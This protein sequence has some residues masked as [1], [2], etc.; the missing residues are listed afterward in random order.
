[1][2][3]LHILKAPQR[4]HRRLI[5][6]AGLPVFAMIVL[7]I[8]GLFALAWWHYVNILPYGHDSHH[9]YAHTLRIAELL[10]NHPKQLVHVLKQQAARYM[11]L[12]Y[13]TGAALIFATQCSWFSSSLM[14]L[15]FWATTLLLLAYFGRKLAGNSVAAAGPLA[16]ALANPVF[17]ETGMSYNLEAPLLAGVLTIFTA[18]YY[19][20]RLSNPLVFCVAACAVVLAAQT[21][22]VFLLPIVP[23]GVV[24]CFTKDRALRWR[25]IALLGA[26][27]FS[28]ALW[29]IPH[30]SMVPEE[31]YFDFDNPSAE[32]FPGRLFYFPV[33]LFGF[34]GA[35][36]LACLA[37]LL[38]TRAK[39]KDLGIEDLAFASFFL[40]PFLFY[41]S[42]ETQRSWYILAAW[43]SLPLWFV[44]SAVRIWERKWVRSIA[45]AVTILYAALG[46]FNATVVAVSAATPPR[47][48]LL[49]GFRRPAPTGS[50]TIEQAREA[51]TKGQCGA[52]HGDDRAALVLYQFF[53]NAKMLDDNVRFNLARRLAW[54]NDKE[55]A[56][57]LWDRLMKK[58]AQFDQKIEALNEIARLEAA[59]KSK[60][61][62]FEKYFEPLFEQ[63]AGDRKRLYSLLSAKVHAAQ[64]KKDWTGAL[65]A[66]RQLREVAFPEQ[67]LGIDLD[68]ALIH[69]KHGS[70]QKAEQMLL[71]IL[72]NN[73]GAIYAEAALHMAGISSMRDDFAS[74]RGFIQKAAKAHCDQN[75]LAQT[76]METALKMES[77]GKTNAAAAL[78]EKALES[79]GG[80]AAS[81]VFIELAKL[82]GRQGDFA[83]ARIAYLE[84]QKNTEDSSRTEWLA[85]SIREIDDAKH[86]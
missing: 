66:V 83:A 36:V 54:L 6:G 27:L 82:A 25:R 59:G 19:A 46:I 79:L 1:M 56:D 22:M 86:P 26:A 73:E 32:N 52:I 30:L 21:K 23:A 60:E 39:D 57:E 48:G 62:S 63:F 67:M 68:E 76:V 50:Y 80:E 2:K 38:Y 53:L 81:L 16:I 71:G 70:V 11:P 29:V 74:A 31:V 15:L 12:S 75:S 7:F 42:L 28:T 18:I 40:I 65:E 55:E 35:P 13:F 24:L 72:K 61:G 9:H 49:S 85:E 51:M 69:Q 58:G 33:M 4:I 34:R 10:Q 43:L 47:H 64:Q 84:A 45:Y 77:A 20:D 14:T 17:W 8:V 37:A 3:S 44:F 41:L 5:D 78:Y